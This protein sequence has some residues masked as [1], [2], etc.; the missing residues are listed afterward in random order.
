MEKDSE[1]KFTN[2]ARATTSPL[3]WYSVLGLPVL[4]VLDFIHSLSLGDL[5]M[6]RPSIANTRLNRN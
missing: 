4:S 5:E 6:D 2:A 1:V 3:L